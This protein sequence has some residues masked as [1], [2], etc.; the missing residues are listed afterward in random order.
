MI[1]I[2]TL[3]RPF[4]VPL[5]PRVDATVQQR[6]SVGLSKESRELIASRF[7]STYPTAATKCHGPSALS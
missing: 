3:T 1:Y 4:R 6:F 5:S 2:N 7:V